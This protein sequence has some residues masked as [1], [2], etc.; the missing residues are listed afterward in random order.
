MSRSVWWAGCS[1]T[2]MTHVRGPQKGPW[3]SGLVPRVAAIEHSSCRHGLSKTL[4]HNGRVVLPMRGPLGL[5][6][7]LDRQLGAPGGWRALL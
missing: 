2:Y 6:D 5:A 7:P 1:D 3:Y 4:P